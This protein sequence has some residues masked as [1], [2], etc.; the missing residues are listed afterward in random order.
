MDYAQWAL[1]ILPP[2]DHFRRSILNI[3]L[4][5]LHWTSGDLDTVQQ[6]FSTL[7]TP[8]QSEDERLFDWIAQTNLARLQAVKGQMRHAKKVFEET[9]AQIEQTN[10]IFQPIAGLSYLGL[11]AIAYQWNVLDEAAQQARMG[12][13]SGQAWMYVKGVLSGYFLLSLIYLAQRSQSNPHHPLD[14]AEPFIR[15][16]GLLP[17]RRRW[18][19]VKARIALAEDDM[20]QAED[21][22]Q[23]MKLPLHGQP[24]YDDEFEYFTLAQI[25]IA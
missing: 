1:N 17:M 12:L 25:R 22:L 23:Q 20:P 14:E 19:A 21:W 2:D 9:L 16:S 13:K 5:Y 18:L 11:A 24:G 4:G 10:P 3:N 7:R 6:I 8:G 15:E